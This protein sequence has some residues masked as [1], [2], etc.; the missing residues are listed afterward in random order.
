MYVQI[1]SIPTLE[2][3]YSVDL[4]FFWSVKFESYQANVLTGTMYQILVAFYDVLTLKIVH[5]NL[6]VLVVIRE[7]MIPCI[8]LALGGNLVDGK[9]TSSF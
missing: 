4:G 3:T 6:I 8:L 2:T 9:L 7:A 5:Y 1:C